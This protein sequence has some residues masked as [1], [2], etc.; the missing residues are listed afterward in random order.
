[1]KITQEEIVQRQ[2]VLLIEME[3]DDLGIYLDRGYRRIVQKT[4]IPGFRKGKA[5][6]AI[7]ER[8]VGR[9]SLLRESLDS[10]LPEITERAITEQSLDTV[11][12]PKVELEELDPLIIKATVALKPEVDLGAYS[13]IRVEESA[14][15][16]SEDAV[17][18]GINRLV[19][20]AGSWVPVERPVA[21]G[22]MVTMTATGSVDGRSILDEKDSV[23]V[24]EEGASTP[25]PGFS[26]SLV[27]VEVGTQ[28]EFTLAVPDDHSDASLAGKEASFSVTVS[29]IKERQLPEL[30]DE[31]AKSVG[32]GF[33]SVAALREH[34]ESNL[35]DQAEKERTEQYRQDVI[36]SL[37][38]GATIELPPLLVEHE[39]EHLV[40]RR[41]Q[42]VDSL[43]IQMDDFLRLTG[44]TEEQTR[45]E[46]KD[47]ATE[48][49]TGSFALTKLAEVEG[50]TVS[51]DDIDERVQTMAASSSDP[52][53]F[54]EN[55]ELKSEEAKDSIRQNI[56][57]ERAVD[58]LVSIARGETAETTTIEPEPDTDG[59][60]EDIEE[61]G[62]TDDAQT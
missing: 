41:A 3:D 14:V 28:K 37:L 9:E 20:E 27:G 46:L 42:F 54:L 12:L 31:F 15:E 58:C 34:V 21:I 16:V 51:E 40:S 35:Q 2:T 8:F 29:E 5:P 43:N 7:V 38:E 13:E 23:H 17:E 48:R 6:R 1:V 32:D 25:V 24:L 22:D 18:E 55:P 44:K 26:E 45:E 61:D 30:D 50:I 4:M 19:S 47:Q 10:M 62:N 36:N 49:I 33:D 57:I 60:T 11:G 56:L 39:L 52:A 53:R 59:G